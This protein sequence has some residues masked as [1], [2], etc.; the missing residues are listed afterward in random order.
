ME[1]LV[2]LSEGITPRDRNLQSRQKEITD[3]MLDLPLHEQ[4][5]IKR[6]EELSVGLAESNEV[7]KQGESGERYR[8]RA[9]IIATSLKDKDEG[10]QVDPDMTV[11][12]AVA[13][14]RQ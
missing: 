1:T 9:V 6:V 11:E 5:V 14:L 13:R 12:Q 8:N 10:R 3:Q 7:E 2:E 4:H